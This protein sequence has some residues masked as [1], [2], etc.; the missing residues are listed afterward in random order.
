V[1]SQLRAQCR[2]ATASRTGRDSVKLPALS[3]VIPRIVQPGGGRRPAVA[4]EPL[5]AT[6]ADDRADR[7]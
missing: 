4:G 5:V 7:A 3:S 2:P 1:R 6:Q